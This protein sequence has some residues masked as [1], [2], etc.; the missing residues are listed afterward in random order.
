MRSEKIVII[1][2][3][4]DIVDVLAYNLSREGFQV[5]SAPDGESG[6]Q[7]IR[8]QMPDLVLLD[9]MLPGFDGID[10]CQRLKASETTRG[11]PIIMITAKGEERDVVLGLGVG[12]DD[13]IV[14]PFSPKEVV[15]RVK[16]ILRRGPVRER[17]ETFERTVVGDLIIDPA[18]HVVQL[19]GKKLGLTPTE[20]SL[21]RHLASQPGRVFR[22]QDLLDRIVGRDTIVIDRT[23]DVHINSIR[24]KLGP[25]RDMVETVR[26]VGYKLRD[27]SS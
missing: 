5:V 27:M 3:E 1:E 22:R 2:D 15:A 10:V 19:K 4:P 9:L 24:K 13:Y 16:A 7:E 12:A 11:I 23:I 21:L 20:F 8:S 17:K 6:L 25:H 14:K 18:C 26:G